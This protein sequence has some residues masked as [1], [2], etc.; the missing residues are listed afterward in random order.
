MPKG[1][2]QRP[3]T[4]VIGPSST[5]LCQEH[6]IDQHQRG[7]AENGDR[8]MQADMDAQH[9]HQG[10]EH[11]AMGDRQD[12]QP[13]VC[14]HRC[15]DE[16]AERSVARRGPCDPRGPPWQTPVCPRACPAWGVACRA[17]SPS[18]LREKGAS[19]PI[20]PLWETPAAEEGALASL[21]LNTP[22]AAAADRRALPPASRRCCRCR[23]PDRRGRSA[24]A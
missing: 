17:A 13:V 5:T 2:S 21:I 18:T 6:C 16:A 23:G 20:S 8:R 4:M 11:D 7:K 14:R 9:Q 3:M 15:G 22:A 1:G 24:P 12:H 10:A 19:R